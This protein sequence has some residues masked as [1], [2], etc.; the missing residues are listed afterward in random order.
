M[1]RAQRISRTINNLYHMHHCARAVAALK[2]AA[3]NQTNHDLNNLAA[4]FTR[5]WRVKRPLLK[6]IARRVLEQSSKTQT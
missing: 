5:Q 6:S 2:G 1:L 4:L 3:T